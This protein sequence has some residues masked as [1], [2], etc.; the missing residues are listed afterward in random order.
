MKAMTH[1]LHRRSAID[2]SVLSDR[3]QPPPLGAQR[4]QS[5]IDGSV[6][7]GYSYAGARLDSQAFFGTVGNRETKG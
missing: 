7:S 5:V 1:L 4:G 3:L 2:L 6:P